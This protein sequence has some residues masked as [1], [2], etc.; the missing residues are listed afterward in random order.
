[1]NGAMIERGKIL[2][3]EDGRYTIQS[4]TRDGL[5]TP[6]LQ[7]ISAGSIRSQ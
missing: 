2:A 6:P 4:Y 5:I 3:A 7:S 1:M